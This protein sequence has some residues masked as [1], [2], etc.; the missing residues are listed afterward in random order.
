MASRIKVEVTQDD[1][2]AA[3]RNDSTRCAVAVA[4]ARTIPDASR[5][6]VDVQ[7]IRYT[8]GRG[9]RRVYLTPQDAERYVI[10]FDAG[11]PIEPFGF[12]LYDSQRV[13]VPRRPFTAEGRARKAAAEAVKYA[14]RKAAKVAA[15]PDATPA[16]RTMAAEQVAAKRERQAVAASMPGPG[17]TSEHPPV[18]D[19]V[20]N[21]KRA[22]RRVAAKGAATNVRNYGHRALR[23]NQR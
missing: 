7:T 23:I 6:M 16:Q 14:E 21:A 13:N 8:D 3:L 19:G 20:I 4:L 17:Q 5:I 9:V 1:I 22:A 10:A 18:D 11:D 15:D 12:G 2:D